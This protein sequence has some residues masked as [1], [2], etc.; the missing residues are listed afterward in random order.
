MPLLFCELLQMWSW[1]E[2]RCFQWGEAAP[3]QGW[4]AHTSYGSEGLCPQMAASSAADSA[5][6]SAAAEAAGG[7]AGRKAGGWA[8]RPE[9][10]TAPSLALSL[11]RWECSGGKSR[12]MPLSEKLEGQPTQNLLT[13]SSHACPFPH[14]P[15][16]E[17]QASQGKEGG[18]EGEWTFEGKGGREGQRHA[19]FLSQ[20]KVI[21]PPFGPLK[22]IVWMPMTIVCLILPPPP[23][24][25]L[26]PLLQPCQALLFVLLLWGLHVLTIGAK[27]T[28]LQ[29]LRFGF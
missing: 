16:W 20:K 1:L 18:M 26:F 12:S 7:K 19:P 14:N 9:T 25:K 17:E 21:L 3:C 28:S 29:R 10:A 15:R 11:R 8:A 5:A 22:T 2:A 4:E 24:K 6:D 23:Q 27:L 13:A